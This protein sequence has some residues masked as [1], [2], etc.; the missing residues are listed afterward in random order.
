MPAL[1]PLPLGDLI[2]LVEA[3]VGEHLDHRPERDMVRKLRPWLAWECQAA[4][5]SRDSSAVV[6]PADP[7]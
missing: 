1:K 2:Q 7:E 6:L 5:S 4:I 3:V